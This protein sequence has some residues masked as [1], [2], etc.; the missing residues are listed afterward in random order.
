MIYESRHLRRLWEV[1]VYKGD[2]DDPKTKTKTETLVAW[3]HVD[4]IRRAPGA[5]ATRP[6]EIGFVTWP[7]GKGDSYIIV[8]PKEG[9][10]NKKVKPSIETPDEE[11]WDF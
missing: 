3:N 10:T 4:A 6:V 9:P 7:D 2:P 1:E 11:D 8:S 5:V